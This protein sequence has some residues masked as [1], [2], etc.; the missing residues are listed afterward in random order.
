M[1]A[2]GHKPTY[3]L[4]KGTSALPP[5]ATA[6]ADFPQTVMSALLPKA[7]ICSA[8]AHVR[9]GPIADIARHLVGVDLNSSAEGCLK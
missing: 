3:A 2:L 6:K 9:F 5:I 1:F 8:Q 4:Q 7:D